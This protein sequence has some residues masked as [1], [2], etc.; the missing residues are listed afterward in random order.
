[1]LISRVLAAAALTVALASCGNADEE[2]VVPVTP[3]PTATPGST[4]LA[5]TLE[6]EHAF[7]TGD[8][9]CPTLDR[10]YARNPGDSNIQIAGQYF[11]KCRTVPPPLVS[12]E[13]SAADVP[14]IAAA[15]QPCPSPQQ[16]RLKVTN[17]RSDNP[18]DYD[19]EW[20]FDVSGVSAIGQPVYVW[21]DLRYRSDIGTNRVEL[22]LG[23]MTV[24]PIHTGGLIETVGTYEFWG[25]PSAADF[26]L[27]DWRVADSPDFDLHDR[28]IHCRPNSGK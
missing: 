22:F 13:L 16:M 11:T 20:K 21:A 1:M 2:S 15:I 14:E 9:D 6:D 18:D 27:V 7:A 19:A 5:M 25:N 28:Y 24:S 4:G 12:R 17:P 26:E 8:H 3:D 10:W 23:P